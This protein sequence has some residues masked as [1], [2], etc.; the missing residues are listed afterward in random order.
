MPEERSHDAAADSLVNCWIPRSA[1][2]T[3]IRNGS[4]DCEF[5]SASVGRLLLSA[6]ALMLAVR[7]QRV[8]ALLDVFSF[9]LA[10]SAFMCRS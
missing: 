7:E 10:Q 4:R 1:S 5:L 6:Y 8:A 2:F 3:I 9:S